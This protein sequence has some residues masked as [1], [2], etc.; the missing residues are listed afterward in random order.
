MLNF[1]ISSG[2]LDTAQKWLIY[3]VEGIGKTSLAMKFPNPL[4][5]DT[6]GSTNHYDVQR[7]PKPTSWQ[8]VNDEVDFIIQTKPCKTL[9]IDTADWLEQLCIVD[10]CNQAKKTSITQFGYGEGYIRLEESFGR[11]LNKLSDLVEVG[12]NVVVTAHAKIVKFEQPDEMGAYDRYELKLGNKTTAKTSSL[13]KEWADT[14]LFLNYQT[15]SVAADDKGTRFKG[16][17][18]RRVM[19][20]THSPCW[21]A[22]NRFGLPEVCPIDYEVIRPYVEARNVVQET[23]IQQAQ[24]IQKPIAQQPLQAPVQ[25]LISDD[26][27]DNNNLFVPTIDPRVPLELRQLMEANGVTEED[28]TNACVQKGYFPQGTPLADYPIDFINGC[29]IGAWPQVLAMINENKAFDDLE[30]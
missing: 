27:F 14:I 3:G 1:N 4:F 12:I 26:P 29:L 13:I 16:Q 15:I 24:Q 9:I 20:T 19:Y 7:L 2:K 17:G 23:P 25:E 28:V 30:F 8:M 21:D 22:K 6:E 18:G 5:I 11:F 10:I